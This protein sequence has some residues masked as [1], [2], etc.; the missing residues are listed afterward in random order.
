LFKRVSG[1]WV[2][3]AFSIK[4]S[5]GATGA[6]GPTGATGAQGPIGNTGPQG[7]T[8]A[9]GATGPQGPAGVTGTITA[10]RGYRAATLTLVAG[11]QRIPIDTVTYDLNQGAA[12]SQMSVSQ[13]RYNVPVA[14]YYQIDGLFAVNPGA[15]GTLVI[16][17][18]YVNGTERARSDR[19]YSTQLNEALELPVTDQLLLAAGDY[20]EL[21]GYCSA[22]QTIE[23]GVA[24]GVINRLAVS[25]INGGAVGPMG[26][27]G[28]P[29]TPK[30]VTANYTAQPFD[31]VIVNAAGVTITLPAAPPNGTIVGVNVG[32]LTQVVAGAGSAGIYR[33][34][35]T[36]TTSTPVANTETLTLVYGTDTYWRVVADT[37]SR[38]QARGHYSVAGS[39]GA[40]A[41]TY[42]GPDTVDYDPFSLFSGGF[43]VAPVA[44]NYLV[45]TTPTIP[46]SAAGSISGGIGVQH[47][48]VWSVPRYVVNVFPASLAACTA[49]CTGIVSVAQGDLIGFAANP[50]FATGLSASASGQYNSIDIQRIGS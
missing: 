50:S 5:T 42:W 14:G 26:P 37:N 7:A 30:V 16:A 35:R 46:C 18:I 4:G 34:G 31:W 32:G 43:Y 36:W 8:G 45:T 17:G 9:Q 15:V 23:T 13:G 20:V 28:I 3:Q 41:W 22:A 12:G 38:F 1:A 48:G 6:A 47:G 11:Y 19:R 44:G 24:G 21:W 40:G 39:L 49:T 29:L 33:C 27:Q 25:L 10:A 2:D